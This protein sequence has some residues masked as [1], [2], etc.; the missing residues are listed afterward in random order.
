MSDKSKMWR[1]PADLAERVDGLIP[2]V[3]ADP[4]LGAGGL[5]GAKPTRADVL[6]LLL[7]RGFSSLEET[8]SMHKKVSG[9]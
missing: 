6:R 5:L 7:V 3:A 1:I 2:L 9:K 4:E 8:I